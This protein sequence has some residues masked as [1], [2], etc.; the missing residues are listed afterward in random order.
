MGYLHPSRILLVVL[1][2]GATKLMSA[3]SALSSLT[4]EQP[5]I[6]PASHQSARA[7]R[8]AAVVVTAGV[9]VALTGLITWVLGAIF[10][11]QGNSA[12]D[13][14]KVLKGRVMVAVGLPLHLIPV[15]AA[16][17]VPAGAIYHCI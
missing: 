6:R 16:G 10:W 3:V 7:E 8:A 17:L 9:I 15:V 1:I 11:S 4:I 2:E 14:A 12:G 5:I 13:A